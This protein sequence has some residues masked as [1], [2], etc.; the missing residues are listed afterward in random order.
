MFSST[1]RCRIPHLH[2]DSFR[3]DLFQA[4][5][6]DEPSL[7]SAEGLMRWLTCKN[8]QLSQLSDAEWVTRSGKRAKTLTSALSKARKYNFFLGL[9]KQWMSEE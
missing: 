4:G 2:A 7:R 3:N 6:L 8:Q 1:S 9:D 5:I